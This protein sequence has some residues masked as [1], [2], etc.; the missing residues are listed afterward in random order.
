M[1]GG[2]I[3]GLTAAL[4]GAITVKNGRVEQSNFHDYLPMRIGEVPVVETHIVR[5]PSLR[6][7]SARLRPLPSLRPW[8][9][10]LCCH[11]Q[12]DPYFAD[13]AVMEHPMT[14]G[15]SAAIC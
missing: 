13:H 2:S 1:E 5:V 7:A 15:M 9:C 4:H 3:F 10:D 14:Y 8:R 11:R 12:A 6:V